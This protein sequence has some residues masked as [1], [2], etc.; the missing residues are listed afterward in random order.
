MTART[1]SPPKSEDLIHPKYRPDIDGLR[2]IAVLSVVI[3]H[4]FPKAIKGGF[5]GVDIF[6]V[7][8]GF[9]ISTII[10]N[11]LEQGTFR[12]SNFYS[13]RVKRI[14][15]ALLLV[16]IACLGFGWFALL[17]EEYKQLGKHV[18]GGAGFVSN[19]LF[20]REAGYFDNAA[21]TKPLLHLW[22]LGIEEQFYMFWPLLLWA[23]WRMRFN[24]L[25]LIVVLLVLSFAFNIT[26]IQ[27]DAVTTFYLL[28]TRVW[29]LLLGAALAQIT[30]KPPSL[31]NFSKKISFAFK[32]LP[33]ISSKSDNNQPEARFFLRNLASAVGLVLILTSIALTTK[34]SSFPGWWAVLPTLGA[35]LIIGAGAQAW[36]N[37]KVLANRGLVWIGLISFPL[38][39]WHWP[40]LSFAKIMQTETP[41]RSIR[42][43]AVAIAFVLAWLTYHLVE[44]P[45][46]FGKRLFT[47]LL[48]LLMVIVGG[49][50]YMVYKYD[51]VKGHTASNKDESISAKVAWATKFVTDDQCKKYLKD[52][53]GDINIFDLCFSNNLSKSPSLFNIGDSHTIPLMSGLYRS[54]DKHAI[55]ADG[56]VG[57]GCLPYFDTESYQNK[58]A[59]RCL[60]P[61]NAAL[62]Y[63][64]ASDSIKLVIMSARG[65]LYLTGKGFGKTEDYMDRVIKYSKNSSVV[66]FREVYKLTMRDTLTRLLA[67]QKKVIFILDIAELGFDPGTC[68]STRPLTI[69]KPINVT[70]PCAVSRAAFNLR[71][72]E[73]RE[74]VRS[75]LKDFPSVK[76]FDAAEEFCDADW[77]WGM[78]NGNMLYEDD[79]HLSSSLGSEL[80]AKKLLP[81]I[82]DQLDIKAS[83]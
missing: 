75:V 80:I 83:H 47:M 37:R 26:K 7:I 39:L 5:V 70:S 8:S 19:F 27:T 18:A 69:G 11:G 28:P 68:L 9:L 22:S 71:N 38:Y 78:K 79:D 49:A 60:N 16:F 61:V 29:E 46:R 32:S 66:D 24:L 41:S 40:L 45:I 77:C 30:L 65:P 63:V 52:G 15:P 2:A 57:L 44:K 3:F 43:A 48:V 21:D 17:A 56:F 58:E 74:I 72:D 35:V 6:F 53:Y 14:F 42:F 82:L 10:L 4:A 34:A 81:L 64:I 13:R 73:Y 25:A 59:K 67:N 23:A 50:G 31:P 33:F 55:S 12:F 62:N 36:V 20:W 76:V 1:A 54:L 51:L